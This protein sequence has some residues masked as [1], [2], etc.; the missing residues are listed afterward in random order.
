MSA[1]SGIAVST[2]LAQKFADAVQTS[3]TRFIKISIEN[4]SLVHDLSLPIAGTLEEDLTKLQDEDIVPNDSPA[5]ILIKLDPPSSDWM[6]IFYVPDTAKVR[7]KMLYA[8]TRP[9][10][11]RSL[12]STSFTDSIFATTKADFTAESYASHLRHN[13]APH[14]LSAREQEMADLRAAENEA[15][16]YQGSSV[17]NSPI[18]TGVGLNWSKEVENA[19]SELGQ[20]NKSTVIIITIDPQT[21]TLIL[22]KVGDTLAASL[23]QTEPCYA[24]VALPHP[25]AQNNGYEIVFVYSCPSNSPIKYRMIYSS[26]STTTYQAA[27]TLLSSLTPPVTL[28]TRKVETSDPK[29]LDE[30][31][32]TSELGLLS[33]DDNIAVAANPPK[34]FAK[35][36][37]PPRRR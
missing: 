1:L 22:H 14:P 20:G 31:Y 9:L 28:S 18:G 11:L 17:R 30:H 23:P 21:E 24:L 26:G 6:N 5:Y 12:G 7:D 33:V 2:D 37:G 8:S 27:K 3:S 15:A 29:E 34:A 13:A 16:N 35:P 25:N 32:L 10:L 36:K 19:V 4:E